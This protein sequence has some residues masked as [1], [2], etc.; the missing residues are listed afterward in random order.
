MKLREWQE[1]A[2]PL[3]WAKKRGIIKV[4]TGGGKT[5]FAIHCL[6][7][8]LE[9]EPNKSILIVVPSIALLDQWYEGISLNFKNKDIALNGGGEQITDL[10]KV[11]I[12]TIDSLKNIISKVEQ[13]STLLIVDEC[14][15]IG[16]EKRGEMLAGNWHATL[17][18]SAT[19]ER[20]YDDNFYIIIK[21]ILG[22]II[23]D[24]DY[25]DA[26][27]DQVIVNFKLLYAYAEMTEAE[28]DKYKDFT[29]KIQRRAAT[30]GGNNMN[31]YPLKMLIFNRA[32]M[33]KN[34]K[35]RIPSGVKLLQ[36]YKRDSWIVF[37]ENKKQAKEFN[38]IINKKGYKS[39]IYNT[40]LDNAEREENLNNFK[41]GNLNV[42]V[43]C[44]ALD[45]GFDMP[46][47]DGAMILSA[48]SSKRQRIQRMGRVL[49]ITA[50]KENALIVTV[51]SS[52][53]EFE[54]LREESTRYKL[55]GVPVKWQQMRL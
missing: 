8:Y 26:R 35:N 33:V 2:F 14:H 3:W 12:T 36:K 28:N 13:Q 55:E 29:K 50:N 25:I 38:K 21:K 45:E 18:L 42:L 34:S 22:D 1:N 7:K 39:A 54:K 24:Y 30:I 15:K 6:K 37:T 49:R 10:S 5:V 20:D 32:R 11:C 23:F 47:A 44:T 48:S 19:P 40:D 4:V 9:E 31:D 27:E 43:S 52:K 17:G 53:T 46:E 16:T 41:S 51:Y